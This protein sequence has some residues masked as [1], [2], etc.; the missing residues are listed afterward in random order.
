M[1]QMIAIVLAISLNWVI[2]NKGK[3]PWPPGKLRADME[4]FKLVT[5]NG[6]VIMGRKT[7]ESIPLKFRPLFGRINIV[8]T[9]QKDYQVDEGVF[10]A[11]SLE[12]AI[13]MAQGIDPD[14]DIFIIGGAGVYEQALMMPEVTHMY[15]TQVEASMEG[16]TTL[17]IEFE[18][19]DMTEDE[20]CEAD[21]KTIFPCR[22]Q[23]WERGAL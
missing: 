9:H 6:F 4:R 13:A 22:F 1:Q 12:Q 18:G 14:R 16:D 15:L 2:G 17:S 21:D 11:S 8:L 3:L 10:V 23:V 7:W 19:W 20:E 5:K